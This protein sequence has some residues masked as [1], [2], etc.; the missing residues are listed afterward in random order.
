MHLIEYYIILFI[1]YIQQSQTLDNSA[2][3]IYVEDLKK[4]IINFIVL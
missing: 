2:K 3:L 4:M 1:Y